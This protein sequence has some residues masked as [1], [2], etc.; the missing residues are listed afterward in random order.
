MPRNSFMHAKQYY[1][2]YISISSISAAYS[3]DKAEARPSTGML[4]TSVRSMM[5]R[6]VRCSLIRPSQRGAAPAV[7][8]VAREHR[9]SAEPVPHSRSD[10][11]PRTPR[12]PASGRDGWHRHLCHACIYLHVPLA[13]RTGIGIN[14]RCGSSCLG[15]KDG[16]Q[17]LDGCSILSAQPRRVNDIIQQVIQAC[18]EY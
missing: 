16:C 1:H 17:T 11:S 18:G 3:D 7:P 4:C 5:A 8:L 14:G 6:G 13:C 15:V 2:R 12:R 9:L 10:A